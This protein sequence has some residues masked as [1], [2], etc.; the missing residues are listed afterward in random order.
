MPLLVS[1]PRAERL[2]ALV[3]SA[4]GGVLCVWREDTSAVA[5]LERRRRARVAHR[6]S[7]VVVDLPPRASTNRMG[8]TLRQCT[9]IFCLSDARSFGFPQ[10]DLVRRQGLGCWIA[11]CVQVC[12]PSHFFLAHMMLAS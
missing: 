8:L 12:P 1:L 7:Y 6:Q 3:S 11:I 5:L 4:A 2:L 10:S 9:L